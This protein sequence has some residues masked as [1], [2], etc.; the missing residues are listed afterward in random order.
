M[1]EIKNKQRINK[2]NFGGI[3]KMGKKEP[4]ERREKRERET[5]R[6]EGGQ[7]KRGRERERERERETERHRKRQR[8]GARERGRARCLQCP[9]VKFDNL[10]GEQ[11]VDTSNIDI[12][13]LVSW[14]VTTRER[15]S[16][17]ITSA[18]L[19]PVKKRW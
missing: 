1:N 7:G 10:T 9:T 6:K 3:L 12:L 16:I 19:V 5:E 15:D 8:G 13:L 11:G 4:K 14:Q 2:T 18:G 17:R